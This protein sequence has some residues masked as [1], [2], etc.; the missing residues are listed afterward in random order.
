MLFRSKRKEPLFLAALFLPVLY[1][2]YQGFTRK[3]EFL[4][5]PHLNEIPKTYAASCSSSRAG[6][7]E[8]VDVPSQANSS[9]WIESATTRTV[10]IISSGKSA[11]SAMCITSVRITCLHF[12]STKQIVKVEVGRVPKWRSNNP[13]VFLRVGLN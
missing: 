12:L 9:S 8:S 5:D 6:A 7:C 2:C 3:E 11:S 13:Q 1:P 4:S 10:P